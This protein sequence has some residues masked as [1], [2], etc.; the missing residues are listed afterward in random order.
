MVNWSFYI[1]LIVVELMLVLNIQH[2]NN[3]LANMSFTHIV[4]F[5]A[6]KYSHFSICVYSRNKQF[7]VH[8][9]CMTTCYCHVHLLEYHCYTSNH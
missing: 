4:K 2:L 6:T 9:F 3:D 8:H 7:I 5:H 1:K